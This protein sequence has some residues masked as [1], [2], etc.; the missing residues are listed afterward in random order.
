V[1]FIQ[2]SKATDWNAII[3][4]LTDL[5]ATS[6]C[7]ALSQD[8]KYIASRLYDDKIWFWDAKTGNGRAI[9]FDFGSVVFAVDHSEHY[10][11]EM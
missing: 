9:I 3:N 7:L 6:H 5:T 2:T 11:C 1:L 4:V 10:S 8:S